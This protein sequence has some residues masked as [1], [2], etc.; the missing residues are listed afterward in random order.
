MSRRKTG[1]GCP[2]VNEQ[3]GGEGASSNA[4][5]GDD[6]CGEVVVVWVWFVNRA[7]ARVVA[8]AVD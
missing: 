7:D 1:M 5:V 4:C 6:N 2:R 3:D 8:A